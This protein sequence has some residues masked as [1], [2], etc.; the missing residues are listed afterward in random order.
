MTHACVL[1]P[2]LVLFTSANGWDRGNLTPANS[3]CEV[4]TKSLLSTSFW[5]ALQDWA[6][7]QWLFNKPTTARTQILVH[8]LGPE[9]RLRHWIATERVT[10]LLV[11]SLAKA[12]ISSSCK[13]VCTKYQTWRKAK[14]G[15]TLLTSNFRRISSRVVAHSRQ[16]EQPFEK[17]SLQGQISQF[18]WQTWSLK[19]ESSVSKRLNQ[20]LTK[21]SKVPCKR[22]QNCWIL[23]VASVCTPCC[24]LLRVVGTCCAKFET[25]ET[26]APTTPNISFVLWSPK[27]SATMLGRFAQLFQHCWGHA[28]E[29]H[30][31]SLNINHVCQNIVARILIME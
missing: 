10:R 4:A 27:R 1:T 12:G 16:R 6:V 2:R 5:S 26:F 28:H 3:F 11:P 14:Q 31:V 15:C 29:L 23:H 13:V 22:T 17:S 24:M 19:E 30:M 20:Y 21:C 8:S 9:Q 25:G 18:C 7:E